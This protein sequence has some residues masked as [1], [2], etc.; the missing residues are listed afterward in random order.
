VLEGTTLRLFRFRPVH[1]DFD[2]FLRD[3]MVPDLAA[4]PGVL[5][6]LSG[7]QGPD[8]LG[9]R[10]VASVW[11]SESAMQAVVGRDLEGSP[12]HPEAL[13]ETVDRSLIISPVAVR[14]VFRP[15]EP[16]IM[17]LLQG[18]IQAGELDLY[19]NDAK[20]GAT[21]DD[22]A[23]HGPTSFHLALTGAQTFVTLSAWREWS[24]IETCTGGDV[25][26]PLATRHPERLVS[27]DVD[28]F[29][30]VPPRSGKG[31]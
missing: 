17:R 1:T 13:D 22:A 25:H 28:H 20:A 26:R 18:R 16:R 23:G 8:A 12:F 30:V 24:D 21:S 27:W 11:E 7:R 14:L 3:V 15:V 4:S 19:V 10:L 6:V 2:A 5:Q 29:E 31:P 9:W